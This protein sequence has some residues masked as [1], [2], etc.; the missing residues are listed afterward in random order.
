MNTLVA[1]APDLW[2][3][4]SDNKETVGA[5]GISSIVAFAFILYRAY[6]CLKQNPVAKTSSSSDNEISLDKKSGKQNTLFL[7]VSFE[8]V[9]KFE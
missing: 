5:V 7:N 2:K 8:Y 9:E 1:V 4:I 3:L 6:L